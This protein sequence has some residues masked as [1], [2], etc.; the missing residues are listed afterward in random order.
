MLEVVY[1]QKH[2]RVPLVYCHQ[3]NV[4]NGVN[5]AHGQTRHSH[6]DGQQENIIAQRNDGKYYRDDDSRDEQGGE[7]AEQP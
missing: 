2:S 6:G 3:L 7:G 4:G 5:D 1:L